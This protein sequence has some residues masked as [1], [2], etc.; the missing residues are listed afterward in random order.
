MS[1]SKAGQ[2]ARCASYVLVTVMALCASVIPAILPQAV[3]TP[4][5]E[6]NSTK[7]ALF[8][9]SDPATNDCAKFD[10]SHNVTGAGAACGGTTPGYLLHFGAITSSLSK[11]STSYTGSPDDSASGTSAA[12]R[13]YIR[14]AG[15]I[16]IA[17][18]YTYSLTAGSNEA[19]SVYVRLNDTSDTLIDTVSAATNARRWTNSALNIA[20][21][22]GDYIEIKDVTPN[23]GTAAQFTS[24]GGY[25]YIQ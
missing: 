9:G 22:A 10:A 14:K 2:W 7:F 13:L 20:V 6:G 3:P 23:W 24:W 11:S 16:K 12:R 4:N 5:K 25:V 21:A 15:A 1:C 19:W 18:L 17:E 8:S